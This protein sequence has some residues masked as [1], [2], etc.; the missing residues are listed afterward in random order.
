ML[1]LTLRGGQGGHPVPRALSTRVFEGNRPATRKSA[2]PTPATQRPAAPQPATGT[3]AARTRS[4]SCESG[5]LGAQRQEVEQQAAKQ[6]ERTKRIRFASTC[7]CPPGGNQD[8][9]LCANLP[10]GLS[11]SLPAGLHVQCL[12]KKQ[13]RRIHPDGLQAPPPPYFNVASGGAKQLHDKN[14]VYF[15][16]AEHSEPATLSWGVTGGASQS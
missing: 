5:R 1:F 2:G 14:T 13:C 9:N 11:I 16:G 6:R 12:R 4:Q 7:G 8:L 3:P 10:V 15:A